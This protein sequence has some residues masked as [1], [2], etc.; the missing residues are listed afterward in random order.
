[1]QL[2]VGLED[3]GTT[4]PDGPAYSPAGRHGWID[5]ADAVGAFLFL[6]GALLAIDRGRRGK[7]KTARRR[8]SGGPSSVPRGRLGFA[9]VRRLQPLR[10]FG[11]FELDFVA[12]GQALEALCLD[13][14]VVDEDILAALDLDE[15][16]PLRIVEPFDGTLCHASGSSLLGT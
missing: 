1:M 7:S 12:L 10:A 2:Q 13:G 3:P 14:A 8:E 5:A 16:V 4:G 6:E 11:D 15:A 9:D